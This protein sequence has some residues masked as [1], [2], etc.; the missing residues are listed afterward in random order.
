MPE[1]FDFSALLAEAEANLDDQGVPDHFGTELTLAEGESWSGRYRGEDED[2]AFDPPRGV[3][4]LADPDGTSYFL[5]RR[6]MLERQ[7]RDA[8]PAVGDYLAVVRGADS[9]TKTGNTLQTWGVSSRPCPDPLPEVA[10]AAEPEAAAAASGEDADGA[11]DED[12]VAVP[13]DIP[14]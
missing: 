14:F 2:R 7:M 4:L 5:R 12:E 9:S 6:A 8:E 3:Y 11:E 10:T 13:D 1:D